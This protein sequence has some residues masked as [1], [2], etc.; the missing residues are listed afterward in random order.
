MRKEFSLKAYFKYLLRYWLVLA[1]CAVIGL[2][3]G[4]GF[5]I[6]T[7][8]N[9]EYVYQGNIC[10]AGVSSLEGL[11]DRPDEYYATVKNYAFDTMNGEPIRNAVYDELAAEWCNLPDNGKLTLSQARD[12]YNKMLSVS[13][14][15]P[16]LYVRFVI[17][18]DDNLDNYKQFAE[19]VINTYLQTAKNAAEKL[20]PLLI[21]K[22]M[23]TLTSAVELTPK[24]LEG[25]GILK[26]GIVG[27]LGGVVVAFIIMIIAYF[28]DRRVLS[29]NDIAYLTGKR[30]LSVSKGY[31]ANNVC[32]GIDSECGESA[33][34]TVCGSADSCANL[35]RLYSE[36]TASVGLKTLMLDFNRSATSG[37]TF[38][39][40]IGGAPIDECAVAENGV[41]V[42]HGE[43]SWALIL[44]AN[45]KIAELKKIYS[46]IVICAPYV[47]DGSTC[48][49]CK[50][51]DKTVF[52]IN[53]KST[54]V[55][56]VLSMA[57][58][59][60]AGDKII[61]AV[62]DCIGKS[63]VGPDAYVET[64]EEEE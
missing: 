41:A 17:D 29:Y 49:L 61:G 20:E 39:E 31:A 21:E 32:P 34:V 43:N 42:L 5:G 52:A 45:S 22:N 40:F 54:D 4:I 9:H 60:N 1:I 62:I 24:E 35:A 64:A 16:F 56:C 63:F 7:K 13:S 26:G 14:A 48:V 38:A 57:T 12:K 19:K 3:C 30:L 59:S 58:E 23:L 50:A 15:G 27:V 47:G 11:G 2:G 6:L 8:Q 55:K 37:D 33:V 51:A 10:I 44:S 28:V 36:Y 46:R 18:G 53:Q 25:I